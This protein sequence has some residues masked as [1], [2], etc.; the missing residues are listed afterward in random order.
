MEETTD[1]RTPCEV[2]AAEWTE[3]GVYW[4]GAV[5]RIDRPTSNQR[6]NL[7][8][9]LTVAGHG[10]RLYVERGSLVVWG[11]FSHYPQAREIWR[12]WPGDQRRPSRLFLLDGSGSITFDALDWLAQQDVPLIRLD[13][14]GRCVTTLGI[15]QPDAELQLRQLALVQDRQASLISATRLIARKLTAMMHVLTQDAP[16]SPVLRCGN[17]NPLVQSECSPRKSHA[18]DR[19]P[20]RH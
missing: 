12:F 15:H 13:Y 16:A 10:A 8:R 2:E 20:S 1:D 14:R 3:R 7:R 6:R 4:L 18:V 19:R 17:Q 9:P 5:A 11:G